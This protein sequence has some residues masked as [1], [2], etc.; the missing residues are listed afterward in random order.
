MKHRVW[1]SPLPKLCLSSSVRLL[2]GRL[3]VPLA[4]GS[5]LPPAVLRGLSV[6]T[7]PP[8]SHAHAGATTGQ[9]AEE[10]SCTP[11]SAAV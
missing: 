5:F 10:T 11:R 3:L 1:I 9:R 6:R 2:R 7:R 8:A 4:L